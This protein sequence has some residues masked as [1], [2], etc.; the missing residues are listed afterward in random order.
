MRKYEATLIR[1][2]M[3][4]FSLRYP[5]YWLTCMFFYHGRQWT[6]YSESYRSFKVLYSLVKQV[7]RRNYRRISRCTVFG[8]LTKLT[9]NSPFFAICVT[10]VMLSSRIR[11][12]SG[13]CPKSACHKSQPI[14]Q[15]LA[16][17]NRPIPEVILDD[18]GSYLNP[19][20]IWS[21]PGRW[22]AVYCWGKKQHGY[23]VGCFIN[24]WRGRGYC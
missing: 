17:N 4:N 2:H 16:S 24:N 20:Q 11:L 7:T 9:R 13:Q 21:V 10:S 23:S 19:W 12:K 6:T 1:D 5:W 18:N 8:G 14:L 3:D 22:E 15:K